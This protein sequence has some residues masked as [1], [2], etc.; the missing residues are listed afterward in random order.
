MLT[1]ARPICPRNISPDPATSCNK[2]QLSPCS[3]A[4]SQH[5]IT[6]IHWALPAPSTLRQVRHSP[7]LACV[8]FLRHPLRLRASAPGPSLVHTAY[9]T[10]TYTSAAAVAWLHARVASPTRHCQQNTPR[11]TH[12]VQP[13]A[14]TPRSHACDACRQRQSPLAELDHAVHVVDVL[15]PA[16]PQLAAPDDI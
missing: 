4:G 2:I 11:A 10:N 5:Y 1:E 6:S 3:R 16:V 15:R 7:A 9:T 13:T 14:P 12:G 8:L